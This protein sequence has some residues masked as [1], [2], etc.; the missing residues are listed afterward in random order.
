MGWVR[1]MEIF[2]DFFGWSPMLK[3]MPGV[4]RVSCIVLQAKH[5]REDERLRGFNVF[6]QCFACINITEQAVLVQSVYIKLCSM[7]S[8]QLAC[9]SALPHDAI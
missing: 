9:T 4:K 7:L 2:A 1:N 6:W 8:L 5:L 3:C